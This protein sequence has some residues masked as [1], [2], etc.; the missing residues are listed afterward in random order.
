MSLKTSMRSDWL[1][2]TASKGGIYIRGENGLLFI[3]YFS[4]LKARRERLCCLDQPPKPAP[5]HS[6]S[7]GATRFFDTTQPASL[8]MTNYLAQAP[9][10][11]AILSQQFAGWRVEMSALARTG[12]DT[13]LRAVQVWQPRPAGASPRRI[14]SAPAPPCHCESL[15]P[16]ACLW[17]SQ[18]LPSVLFSSRLWCGPAQRLSAHAYRHTRPDVGRCSKLRKPARSG[19]MPIRLRR[20][21]WRRP[22]ESDPDDTA[23]PVCDRPP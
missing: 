9:G 3:V 8:E 15:F 2:S 20:A 5:L 1:F 10:P 22:D 19:Q 11:P 6:R 7:D 23:A 12:R 14:D 21:N 17:F 18:A 16:R 4:D 13:G